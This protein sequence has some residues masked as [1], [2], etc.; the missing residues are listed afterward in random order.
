MTPLDTLSRF[1]GLRTLVIGEAMLDRYLTGHVE[2]LCR[3][4]PVPIVATEANDA[5]PGGAAN[6]AAAAAAL[7]AKVR[8]VSAVGDDESGDVLRELLDRKGVDTSAVLPVPGRRT[9][10]KQRI[11]AGGQLLLRIDAGSEDDLDEANE[12]R[13]IHAIDLA[14]GESDAVVLSDYG[15]GVLTDRVIARIAER[16]CR[17]PRIVI[18]DAKHLRRFRSIGVTAAKPN[19]AEALALCGASPCE[20]RVSQIEACQD[21]LLDRTRAGILT[22]TIDVAGAIVFEPG[23][24]PYRTF[25]RAAPNAQAA[26]AGDVFTATLAL[27]LTAGADGPAAADLAAGAATVCVA[28][29]GTTTC[30]ASELRRALIGENKVVDVAAA[31]AQVAAWRASGKRLVF[32]NGCFDILHRGHVTYLNRAKA[33]GDMLIVGLN[34]DASIRRLKGDGRPIN[35]EGDRANVLAALSCIDLVVP[36]AEDTPAALIEVLRPEVF[37]KGG[38]YTLDTL[39]EAALVQRLGGE[40]ILLPFLD[41]RSTTATI[42]R[43]RSAGTVRA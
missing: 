42:A 41:D 3:E 6:T 36:F 10:L 1:A 38:D 31:A 26:G 33:L 17:D 20:N 11:S 13:L 5:A 8:L 12:R 16:Q 7:G 9:L 35:G 24:P 4:A 2:R 14:W 34:T 27:A 30:S 19:Y 39:P 28:R 23:R 15:Y 32:T 21:T 22:V 18:A 25:T 40:V 37:A 29:G 43:I